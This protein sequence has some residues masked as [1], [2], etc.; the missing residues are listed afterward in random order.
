MPDSLLALL[1]ALVVLAVVS[2]VFRWAA[3]SEQ[4]APDRY[5]ASRVYYPRRGRKVDLPTL[6]RRPRTLH[7]CP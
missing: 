3:R 7:D 1:L 5:L 2:L 4:Q 6:K